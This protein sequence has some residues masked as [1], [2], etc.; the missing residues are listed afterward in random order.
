MSRGIGARLP[1]NEDLRHLLG[2]GEFIADIAMPD[3]HDVA[4]L[5]SP[6]AHA[7]ILGIEP[8]ADSRARVFT[9]ADFDTLKPIRSVARQSTGFYAGG[10]KVGR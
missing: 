9:S 3:L 7:R 5:R 2:R 4:F 8:P 6:V 10:W 1:R